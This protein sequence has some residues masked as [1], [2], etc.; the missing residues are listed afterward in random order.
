MSSV[1][2]L[3]LV[4]LVSHHLGCSGSPA[5]SARE[6]QDAL[7]RDP[8]SYKNEDPADISGGKLNEFDRK[9]MQKDL[10]H[11]FNP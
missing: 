10:D 1:L 2:G 9:A 5:P 11:V 3:S 8:F 7:L 4:V 6:R